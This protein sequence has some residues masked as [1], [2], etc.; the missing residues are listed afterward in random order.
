MVP[1]VISF[2]VSENGHPN[3]ISRR[4]LFVPGTTAITMADRVDA[5]CAVKATD[6][7]HIGQAETEEEVGASDLVE[8]VS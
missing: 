1:V 5:P 4:Y 6:V 2:S 7:R 8:E 3:I